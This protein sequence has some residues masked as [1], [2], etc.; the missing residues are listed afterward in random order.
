MNQIILEGI[1]GSTAYGLATPESDIDKL[2]IY[3]QP[4]EDF[5]GLK[6]WTEKDFSIVTTNPDRTLHELGKFCRLALKCNPTITE[7]LWIPEELITLHTPEGILL[8]MMAKN[9]LSAQ[10]SAWNLKTSSSYAD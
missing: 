5:Y 4:T 10:L 7:L 1:V 8:R 9:F 6:L 3:I 2:G